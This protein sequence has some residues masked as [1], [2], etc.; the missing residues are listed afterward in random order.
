MS[1]LD[2]GGARHPLAELT[3][4]RLREFLREPEALF[5]AFI[6]PIVL[7]LALA[8][9][10][11]GRAEQRVTVGISAQADAAALRAALEAADGID[12]RTVE[13]ADEL[14][15][16]RE[17]AVHLVVHPGVP[18]EYRFDAAREESRMARLVVDDALKRAAGRVD[19]WEAREDRIDIAGSRYVDW[20]IPGIVGMNIMGNSLWGLGFSIV[21]LRLRKIL[22]RLVASPMRRWEFLLAQILARMLFLLPE[23][24]VPIAFGVLAFGMPVRGSIVDVAILCTVGAL[25]FSGLGLLLASRP[26]TFEAI[27]GVM[28]L[29]MLPMWILSG[30]FFSAANFPDSIQW[31][32]QALPLTGLIDGLRAIILEGASLVDIRHEVALLALWG[33]VPFAI[34]LRIFRWR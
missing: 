2:R 21:Q 26:R 22:K 15:A 29:V 14:R 17:G 31:F 27:S 6:F 3:L 7:S 25:G 16:L 8:V 1:R 9:A 32:V 33:I 20:L 12:L 4:A 18:P 34:T 24:L 5:W 23:V 10:F 28:N 13:P 11:P 30:I 19:P